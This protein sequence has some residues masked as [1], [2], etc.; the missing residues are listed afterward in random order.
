[1]KIKSRPPQPGGLSGSRRVKLEQRPPQTPGPCQQESGVFVC[2][3]PSAPPA[4]SGTAAERQGMN[5][6]I[7]CGRRRP[8]C[9][10]LS[11]KR[12]KSLGRMPCFNRGVV[13]SSAN[14]RSPGRLPLIWKYF[15][16]CSP[17][18]SLYATGS[19]VCYPGQLA[20]WQLLWRKPLSQ[21]ESL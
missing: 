12:D 21:T 7:R 5:K 11:V 3:S 13:L 2:L 4:P 20:G 6:H 8:V 17:A 18:P 1:M 10:T 16:S 9:R 15:A 14:L 19:R